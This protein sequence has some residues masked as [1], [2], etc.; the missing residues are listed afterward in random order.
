MYRFPIAI[1]MM[2]CTVLLARTAIGQNEVKN[3]FPKERLVPVD[4]AEKDE[5]FYAYY[6]HL[7]KAV[8]DKDRDALLPLI[9]DEIKC[10]FGSEDGIDDFR[11]TWQLNEKPEESPL[12][13]ELSELIR[14]GGKFQSYGSDDESYYIMPSIHVDFPDRM[15]LFEFEAVTGLHVRLREEPNTES[16]VITLVSYQIV[17]PIRSTDSYVEDESHA[18]YHWQKIELFDGT[19]GYIWSKYLRSPIGLRAMFKKRP[20]GWTMVSL[21]AGD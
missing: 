4:E 3:L 11:T 16:R 8:E 18:H 14:L 17:R 6:K 2:A 12:W 1:A 13:F 19:V 21:L 5:G 9:D 7:V 10:S 20:E 15:D